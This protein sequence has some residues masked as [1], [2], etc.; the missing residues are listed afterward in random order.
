M[1]ARKAMN[2]A[3]KF[4]KIETD[5]LAVK[6]QLCQTFDF[7]HL[8]KTANECVEEMKQDLT[9]SQKMWDV[10]EVLQKFVTESKQILWSEMDTNELDEQSKNQV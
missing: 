10:V 7:P 3:A 6:S 1:E 5:Q 4:L 8:V 9:E 2:D